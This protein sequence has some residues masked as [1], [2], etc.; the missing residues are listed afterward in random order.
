MFKF[1]LVIEKTCIV[2]R[3]SKV[4]AGVKAIASLPFSAHSPINMQVYV[5]TRQNEGRSHCL[6]R[7]GN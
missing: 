7:A 2:K 6:K 4:L 3:V 5:V 1:V